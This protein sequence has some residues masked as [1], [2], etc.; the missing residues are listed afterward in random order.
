[1]GPTEW[2][3]TNADVVLGDEKEQREARRV[4]YA[5]A[6]LTGVLARKWPKT[7]RNAL[8]NITVSEQHKALCLSALSIADEMIRQED[9]RAE[10]FAD[11]REQF[12]SGRNLP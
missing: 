7:T 10:T 11:G 2:H 1:M 4:C 6:A 5:A 12:E 8:H 9:D 3:Q